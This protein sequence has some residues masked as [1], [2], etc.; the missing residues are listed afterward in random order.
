[1]IV[2]ARLAEI[3][4]FIATRVLRGHTEASLGISFNLPVISRDV[5]TTK[6]HTLYFSPITGHNGITSGTPESR[7]FFAALVGETFKKTRTKKKPDERS[8]LLHK[9]AD[10]TAVW[11]LD[12][13]LEWVGYI[14]RGWLALAMLAHVLK[15]GPMRM[16]EEALLL[17]ARNKTSRSHLF[18]EQVEQTISIVSNYHKGFELTGVEKEAMFLMPRELARLFIIMLRV[19]RPV[20]VQ[21]VLQDPSPIKAITDRNIVIEQY[22]SHVYIGAGKAILQD[23]LRVFHSE[24]FRKGTSLGW[25]IRGQNRKIGLEFNLSVSLYRQWF[26]AYHRRCHPGITLPNTN[27]R[28]DK[29]RDEEGQASTVADRQSLHTTKVSGKH[30]GNEHTDHQLVESDIKIFKEFSKAVQRDLWGIEWV[31]QNQDVEIE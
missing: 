5:Q 1:M 13:A 4:E 19:V 23:E 15:G 30:Y 21:F 20:E 18:L 12:E 26:T 8:Q 2:L 16:S 29:E 17:F 6:G 28:G 27:T 9:L 3:E 25:L 14:R 11:C 10:G 24:W 31:D 7:T 22:C